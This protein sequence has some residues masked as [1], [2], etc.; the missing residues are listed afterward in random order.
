MSGRRLTSLA[1]LTVLL[2]AHPLNALA[3]K[4]DCR[5]KNLA[6]L[7]GWG[8]V[9]IGQGLETGI[10]GRDV[11]GAQTGTTINWPVY[12]KLAGWTAP[13]NDEGW[14]RFEGMLDHVLAGLKQNGGFGFPAMMSSPAP[15]KFVIGLSETALIS[16]YLD[17][18]YVYTD[19]RGHP[20][21]GNV[22]PTVW[23]DSIGCWKG[24]TLVIETTNVKYSPDFNAFAAPLSDE[25][26][27]VE[28]VRLVAPGRLESDITVTDPATLE[29]PWRL[30][31]TYVRPKGIDRLIH[32][33]DMLDNDR[34]VMTGD[35]GTI[36]PPRER[37][38]WPPPLGAADAELTEADMDRVAGVYVFDGAPLKLKV[39]RRGQKLFFAVDPAQPFWL[40][41]HARSALDFESMRAP[42]HFTADATG[43]VTGF[44]GKQP[45]GTPVSGKRAPPRP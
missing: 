33:G 42:F 24:S 12:Y 38:P 29:R 36:T 10:N 28:R 35:A 32:D 16:E 8:G 3:A 39:E 30:T 26:R 21:A 34:S 13:W 40:P 14:S 1:A 17:V 20:P 22:W 9:W 5:P 7:S 2:A 19:G 15:F 23:G 41:L 27:Y 45:D 43:Q 44:T 11:L 25:A 6:S 18:R 31:M 4:A 37:A